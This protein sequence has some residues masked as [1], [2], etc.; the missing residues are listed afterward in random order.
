MEREQ[1]IV[2]SVNK[3]RLPVSPATNLVCTKCGTDGKECSVNGFHVFADEIPFVGRVPLGSTDMPTHIIN[4]DAPPEKRWSHILPLYREASG[5]LQ[6]KVAMQTARHHAEFASALSEFTAASIERFEFGRE[7][8]GIAAELEVDVSQVMMTQLWLETSMGCSSVVTTTDAGLI[9]GERG[10]EVPFIIRTMDWGLEEMRAVTFQ[11]KFVRE[12][13]VVFVATTAAGY[14][15]CITGYRPGCF[16]LSINYRLGRDLRGGLDVR[17]PAVL[18]RVRAGTQLGHAP[19]TFMARAALDA[20]T[21]YGAIAAH[22]KTVELISPCYIAL[23]GLEA[24]EGCVITRSPTPAEQLPVW[25]LAGSEPLDG[26]GANCQTN[27]DYFTEGDGWA[28]SGDL[29]RPWTRD[30]SA[31]GKQSCH[32]R[33]LANSGFGLL[34]AKQKEEGSVGLNPEDLWLLMSVMPIFNPDTIYT[35][36]MCPS[37]DHYSSRLVLCG[38]DK[39]RA[40]RLFKGEEEAVGGGAGAERGPCA[41]KGCDFRGTP[42]TGGYC[43]ACFKVVTQGGRAL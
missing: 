35:T 26:I 22:A 11:A 36:S 15:G 43:S 38:E 8:V 32:R 5:A 37:T 30:P 7:M 31:K 18:R 10:R 1:E 2:K 20:F 21:S 13:R 17:V 25:E 40:T 34:K 14:V 28:P 23:C 27:D 24:G 39:A 3:A 16:G 19:I 6:D 33:N 42:E 4:L 9:G 41:A 12:G 29:E